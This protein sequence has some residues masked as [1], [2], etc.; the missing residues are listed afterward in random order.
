MRLYLLSFHHGILAIELDD[1]D[2][3]PGTVADLSRVAEGFRFST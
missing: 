1:I 2:Q 3:A